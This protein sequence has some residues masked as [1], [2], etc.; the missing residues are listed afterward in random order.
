MTMKS[1]YLPTCRIASVRAI[2]ILAVLSALSFLTPASR[3]GVTI[4]LDMNRNGSGGSPYYL[5]FPSLVTNTLTAVPPDTGYFVWSASSAIDSGA[6]AQLLPDGSNPYGGSSYGDDYAALL[7]EMTNL[8]TLMVTNTTSTNI[9]HFR[10]SSFSSNSLPL[11]TLIF[12]LQNS[13]NVTNQPTFMWHGPTNYDS[14]SVQFGEDNGPNYQSAILSPSQTN[15][16]VPAPLIYADQDNFIFSYSKDGSS[17]IV[18]STPTN[19]AGQTFPGWTSTCGLTVFD[20]AN[21]TVTDPFAGGPVP[22]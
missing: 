16:T 20:G 15:W 2:L 11:A 17:I 3:A 14:L 7:Q 6:Y 8:W 12:P 9:Y 18:S 5:V 13:V 21:F 22:L 4:H 1:I 10:L 19:G